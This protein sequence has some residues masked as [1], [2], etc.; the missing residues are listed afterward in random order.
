MAASAKQLENL[1]RARAARAAKRAGTT[2]AEPAAVAVGVVADPPRI[3]GQ[4]DASIEQLIVEMRD[5]FVTFRDQLNTLADKVEVL[6]LEREN[7]SAARRLNEPYKIPYRCTE[8]GTVVEALHPR[9]R[10]G[11]PVRC[12]NPAHN[13]G[14]TPMDFQP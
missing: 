4:Y 6:W 7:G 5:D 11:Q 13:G 12:T 1:A 2:V 3:A 9:W 10:A 8:C 14:L